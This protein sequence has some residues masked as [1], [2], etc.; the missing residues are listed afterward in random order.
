[1]LRALHPG[2]LTSLVL[3]STT[4]AITLV[5]A[6]IGY[7]LGRDS[8][9]GVS[10]PVVNPILGSAVNGNDQTEGERSPILDEAQIIAQTKARIAEMTEGS[11]DRKIVP[12]PTPANEPPAAEPAV[13]RTL[14]I[15]AEDKGVRLEISRV[16]TLGQDLAL[17]VSLK[18]DSSQGVQFIYTF[19]EITNDKGDLLSALTEGLPTE[20]PAGSD[21]V[22]GTI[23][24]PKSLLNNTKT[25]TLRL[26]SYPNQDV[27]L[28]AANI[29]V[30]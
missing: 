23:L 14:P 16:D 11:S 22:K 12:A 13:S 9:R 4:T 28:Q 29:P 5:T 18:N 8:L 10:Q 24:I 20:L 30:E 6:F 21:L 3:I 25:L 15:V 27:E 2:I 1:M 17:Q 7:H 26:A 19:L